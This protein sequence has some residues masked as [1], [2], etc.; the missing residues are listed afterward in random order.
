MTYPLRTRFMGRDIC[1]CP[2]C[3]SRPVWVFRDLQATFQAVSDAN[4][5]LDKPAETCQG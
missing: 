5:T 3:Q 2:W 4:K 1:D